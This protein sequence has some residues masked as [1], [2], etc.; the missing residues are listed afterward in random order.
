M[1]RIEKWLLLSVIKISYN[2][3]TIKFYLSKAGAFHQEVLYQRIDSW[4]DFFHRFGVIVFLVHTF[5]RI[6]SLA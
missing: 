1:D 4:D 5:L 6:F 2:F 3:G